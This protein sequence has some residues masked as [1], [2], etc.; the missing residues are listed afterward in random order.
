MDIIEDIVTRQTSWARVKRPIESIK[1]MLFVCNKTN[2]VFYGWIRFV[3][4]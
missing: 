3:I 4:P 2:V 1:M